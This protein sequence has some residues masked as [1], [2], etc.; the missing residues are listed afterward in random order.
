[1]ASKQRTTHG[2][3]SPLFLVKNSQK[4]AITIF[5]LP[6]Q[7]SIISSP[8]NCSSPIISN[9]STS[10]ILKNGTLLLNNLYRYEPHLREYCLEKIF[11][12][13]G[14]FLSK[15][16]IKNG[17]IQPFTCSKWKGNKSKNA[18]AKTLINCAT[19]FSCIFL[20]LTL[21]VYIILPDL[22]NTHGKTVICH[23]FVMLLAF[24]LRLMLTMP[25][26][27]SYVPGLCLFIGELFINASIRVMNIS[28]CFVF[29]YVFF[30]GFDINRN[31]WDM[32]GL[33]CLRRI[34]RGGKINI[35]FRNVFL[36]VLGY[37]L[38]YTFVATFTWLNTMCFDIWWTFG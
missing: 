20:L 31:Y 13:D 38:N 34:I 37:M 12:D 28:R 10:T 4:S 18:I 9:A 27:T 22:H 24:V 35:F 7:L 26:E 8:P 2:P 33:V 19:I 6:G 14:A 23:T 3:T 15:S 21:V 30:F 17:T 32:R 16:K 5:P 11:S 25:S 36:F 1:M 29:L